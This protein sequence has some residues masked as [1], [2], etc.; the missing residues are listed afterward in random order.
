MCKKPNRIQKH[1]KFIPCNLYIST[2]S[3]NSQDTLAPDRSQQTFNVSFRGVGIPDS[4]LLMHLTPPWV[5]P[6]HLLH[7]L[8]KSS[9]LSLCSYTSSFIT[10]CFQIFHLLFLR[11]STPLKHDS[12]PIPCSL[13]IHFSPCHSPIHKPLFFHCT[14]ITLCF[15]WHSQLT[16]WSESCCYSN[17]LIKYWIPP[18]KHAAIDIPFC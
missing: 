18:W 5:Q 11:I 10:F 3:T 8:W 1:C 16:K 9:W 4:R 7:Y 15:S 6:G 13:S 17:K 2:W 12:W 14:K